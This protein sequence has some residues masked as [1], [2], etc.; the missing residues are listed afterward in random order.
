MDDIDAGFP[1]MNC[2]DAP[3]AGSSNAERRLRSAALIPAAGR[4]ERLGLGPKA[5]LRLGDRTLLEIV[6]DAVA[7]L[8]SELIVAAPEEYRV[9]FEQLLKGRADVVCGGDSRQESVDAMVKACSAD[10]LLLQDVARPFATTAL[11]AQV[12]EAAAAHGAAGAFVDPQVPVGY[13]E[14]GFV[15]SQWGRDVARVFQ[16]PQAF[17][18]EVLED[19]RRASNGQEFQSTAQL[20]ICAGFPLAAVPGC[21]E[22][23]KITSALDWEIARKVISPRLGITADNEH[24][25]LTSPR[26]QEPVVAGT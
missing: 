11:C 25:D 10:L 17:R 26:Q 8:V 22:N 2:P 4:G 13:E 20:L 19:A 7:P 24:R 23:I 15:G 9:R 18:R 16:A 1:S 3:V 21:A 5:L 12:L 14:Q 6:V